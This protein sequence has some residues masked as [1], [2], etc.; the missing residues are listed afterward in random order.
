M[1]KNITIWLFI[2]YNMKSKDIESENITVDNMDSQHIQDCKRIWKN[3]MGDDWASEKRIN[4]SIEQELAYVV[5]NDGVVLGFCIGVI[6][7]LEN[8]TYCNEQVLDSIELDRNRYVKY[9]D[10]ICVNRDFRGKGIGSQLT[11]KLVDK[12]RNIK[13]SLPIIT[14]AWIKENKADGT[15]LLENTRFVEIYNSQTSSNNE[16]NESENEYWVGSSECKECGKENC[17]CDGAMYMDDR[18]SNKNNI[19]GSDNREDILEENEWI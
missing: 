9:I 6:G 1:I 3:S 19:N 10:T 2:Y 7:E 12:L 8:I 18:V 14:E 5:E 11:N 13:K 15:N 4:Q 16:N 17:E